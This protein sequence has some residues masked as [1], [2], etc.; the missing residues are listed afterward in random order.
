MK[1]LEAGAWLAMALFVFI[2]WEPVYGWQF[3]G[4]FVFFFLIVT[5]MVALAVWKCLCFVDAWQDRRT[6]QTTPED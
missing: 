1:L 4:S 6:S 3:A 5:P 2:A